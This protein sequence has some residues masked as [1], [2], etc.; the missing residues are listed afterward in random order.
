MVLERVSFIVQK[1][2]SH[3][4]MEC[5]PIV[6]NLSRYKKN[7]K[8]FYLIHPSFMFK[9]IIKCFRPFVSEKVWKKLLLCDRFSQVYEDI[10]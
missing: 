3:N 2:S 4:F 10:D 1:V 9:M 7:L 6:N 8:S 5:S